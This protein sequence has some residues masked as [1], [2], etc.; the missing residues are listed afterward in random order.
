MKT[1]KPPQA[2]SSF[3]LRDPSRTLDH[4]HLISAVEQLQLFLDTPNDSAFAALVGPTGAGKSHLAKA[5]AN[6]IIEAAS[7][8]MTKDLQYTP[9]IYCRLELFTTQKNYNWTNVFMQLLRAGGH[10][11]PTAKDLAD[12]RM[13]W[14]NT[15]DCRRTKVIFLDESHHVISGFKADDTEGIKT[16]ADIVKSIVDGTKT[17]L[18]LASSYGIAPLLTGDAQLIRRNHRV[19]LRR[20]RNCPED[21]EAFQAMLKIVDDTFKGYFAFSLEQHE[22]FLYEGCLG[23]IGVLRDWLV[24]A[25]TRAPKAEESVISLATLSACR[26]DITQLKKMHEDIYTK[27][28]EFYDT[29]ETF[30]N[31]AAALENERAE[32]ERTSVGGKGKGKGKGRRKP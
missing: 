15:L 19:H 30:D 2:L 18:V 22:A 20:Y 17:K 6:Q 29:Q 13:K 1:N 26:L 12:A 10:V 24:L 5:L 23:L 8:E 3:P 25:S 14:R 7:E 21:R 32:L 27:E 11:N 16:Q 31:F 4:A 28:R 9:A